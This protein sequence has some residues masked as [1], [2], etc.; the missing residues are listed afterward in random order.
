MSQ[1]S[2]EVH[3]KI[4]YDPDAKSGLNLDPKVLRNCLSELYSGVSETRLPVRSTLVCIVHT[5]I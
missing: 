3:V 4:S 2:G 1:S 5:K